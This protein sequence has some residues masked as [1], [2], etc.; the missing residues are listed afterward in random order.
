MVRY[1]WG[2]Y[3]LRNLLQPIKNSA[4]LF[5]ECGNTEVG[6]E[7]EKE[8]PVDLTD[9]VDR[10]TGLVSPTPRTTRRSTVHLYLLISHY[11]IL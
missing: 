3:E 5:R 6:Y 8:L 7:V 9:F 11:F 10:Q 1:C 2:S 4:L